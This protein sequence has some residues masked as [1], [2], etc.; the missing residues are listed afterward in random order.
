MQDGG[1]S[2]RTPL[3]YYILAEAAH[4]SHGNGKKLGPVGSTILAEVL[5][6][7]ARRSEDSILTDTTWNGPTLPSFTPGTFTLT[8]LLRFAGVL[9]QATPD[10]FYTVVAGDTLSIIAQR[11]YGD[12]GRW[13]RIFE[14]NQDQ[15]SN[16]NQIFPGQVLR[17]PNVDKYTV[18]AGD[19]LS[20]IAQK[21]YKQANKWPRIFDANRNQLNDPNQI[22]PGQVLFI[23]MIALH[24]VVGG[25]SLSGIAQQFYGNPN[26][27]PRIFEANRDQISNPNQVFGGQILRIPLL[28]L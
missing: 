25:D 6:G 3:W 5:I 27:F 7:L 11:L 4:P 22:V 12:P 26:R 18:L 10:I 9:D 17:I 13:P 24:T 1:F 16:P 2:A 14:V 20:G 15:L 8:D 28:F 19:S 23:P 21:F